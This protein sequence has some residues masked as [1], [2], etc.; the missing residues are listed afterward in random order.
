MVMIGHQAH[1]IHDLAPSKGWPNQGS[2]ISCT[3]KIPIIHTHG[4]RFFPMFTTITTYPYIA[5]LTTSPF[6]WGWDFNHWVKWMLHY[7]LRPHMH[8]N[9]I[10]K[11]NMTKP[12]D[13]LNES[14]T[15]ANRFKIFCKSA[16]PSI[17]N[18]MINT[19]CHTSFKWEIKF[20][21]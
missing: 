3:C 1:Q 11:L 19:G 10:R 18:F 2:C 6:L 13:S 5:Q 14:N 20:G 8:N 21:C 12:P 16:M 17:S 15:S 4:M 9:P 7:P